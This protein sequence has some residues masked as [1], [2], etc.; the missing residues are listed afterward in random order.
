MMKKYL[1][2]FPGLCAKHLFKVLEKLDKPAHV[3]YLLK[4]HIER[5]KSL[6]ADLKEFCRK[7]DYRFRGEPS[8][9]EADSWQKAVYVVSGKIL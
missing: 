8:G 2:A 6:L 4:L 1:A 3:R 5:Y 9:K 7:N